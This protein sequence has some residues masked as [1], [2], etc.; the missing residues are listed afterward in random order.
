MSGQ[1]HASASLPSGKEAL[2]AI[3]YEAVWASES[4]W[5]VLG[6]SNGGYD[7]LVMEHCLDN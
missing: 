4:V 7:G 5:N 2:L 6:R 3:E 1:L